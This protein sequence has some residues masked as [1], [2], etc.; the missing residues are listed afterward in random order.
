MEIRE[1]QVEDVMATYPHI[2]QSLLAVDK[3]LSLLAREM[4]LPSGRLD[5]LFASGNRILLLEL[6]VEECTGDFV[7]QI[8]AYREDL[9]VL[10]SQ[11]ML[12]QGDIAAILLCTGFS[13]RDAAL[14]KSQ[15]VIALTYSPEDILQAFFSQVQNTSPFMTIRP[16]DS[17]LWNIHLINRIVYGLLDSAVI[18]L[19]EKTGL[20]KRSVSNHLRFAEQLCL[21]SI[22][23]QTTCLT[24]LGQRYVLAQDSRLPYDSVSEDQARLLKDFIVRDPFVTPTVFGIYQMIEAVFALSRNTY[25]V[26]LDLVMPYFRD[27]CGKQYQWQTSRSI[28]HGT[29]MYSNYGIELGL[30]GKV[31]DKLM[32]TPNGIRF[33][34]LLQLHK[35]IKMVDAL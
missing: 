11:R 21:V 2:T 29:R 24:D 27:A 17:G 8:A 35:G 18:D 22:A 25:P 4:V 12:V 28:Y 10:Q 20:S 9:K 6:K 1:S 15:D 31:S 3:Q 19:P 5:L 34:L 14:C 26:P 30:L 23:N 32:L 7:T 33:I 16:M 13:D